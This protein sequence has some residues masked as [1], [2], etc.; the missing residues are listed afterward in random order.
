MKS[1][2]KP[3]D[4]LIYNGLSNFVKPYVD[5]EKQLIYANS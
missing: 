5:A 3:I 2:K 1:V 4:L